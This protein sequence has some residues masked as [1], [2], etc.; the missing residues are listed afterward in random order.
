M[1]VGYAPVSIAEQNPDHHIDALL[2]AGVA[3]KTGMPAG[4]TRA[5]V[6]FFAAVVDDICSPA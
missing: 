3:R 6:A 1:L 2:R 5:A 4:L